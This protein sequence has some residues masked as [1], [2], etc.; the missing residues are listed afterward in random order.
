MF[1]P[2]SR[3]L[4]VQGFRTLVRTLGRVGGLGFRVLV[5]FYFVWGFGLRGL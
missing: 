4:K 5:A 1:G 3:V 2:I